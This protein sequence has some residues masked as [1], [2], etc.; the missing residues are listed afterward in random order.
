MEYNLVKPDMQL[1][2]KFDVIF[3]RN[4]LIYFEKPVIVQ[5]IK[6][7]MVHLNKGGLLILGLA[8]SLSNPEQ[9][10]LKR[11]ESSVYSK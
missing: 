2:K 8:E 9:Y 5:I 4:V 10:Q 3:L 11:L 1:N 6:N 7:L